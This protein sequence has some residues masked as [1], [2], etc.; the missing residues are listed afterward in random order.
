[1]TTERKGPAPSVRRPDGRYLRWSWRYN[2]WQIK[3]RDGGFKNISTPLA[4]SY[5]AAG[6]PIGVQ[7]PAFPTGLQGEQQ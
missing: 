1:M 3:T 7:G 6:L 4:R 2:A 5:A